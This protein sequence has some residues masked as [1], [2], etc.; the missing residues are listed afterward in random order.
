MRLGDV[1]DKIVCLGIAMAM[2]YASTLTSDGAA[3]EDD[4]RSGR[5]REPMLLDLDEPRR[6]E[7]AAAS[8]SA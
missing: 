5:A 7:P 1:L 2:E 3:R 4:D 6:G 8:Y